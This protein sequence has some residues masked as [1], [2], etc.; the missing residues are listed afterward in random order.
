M[1]GDNT[2]LISLDVELP[3]YDVNAEIHL[4]LFYLNL[5]SLLILPLHF[6]KQSQHV[7]FLHC[8]P[9][10]HPTIHIL[11]TLLDHV[12]ARRNRRRGQ[13]VCISR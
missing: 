6:H 2:A 4:S 13:G 9:L 10:T 5:L 7:F 11:L 12:Q 1:C 8:E 3:L